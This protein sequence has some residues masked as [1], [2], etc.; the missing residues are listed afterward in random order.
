MEEKKFPS[1]HGK[2]V[3]KYSGA[4]KIQTMKKISSQNHIENFVVIIL[5][6]FP[7]NKT[8]TL[9][10]DFRPLLV[11]WSKSSLFDSS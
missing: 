6:R 4:G 9:N 7:I 1:D 8:K 5:G 10:D 3:T 11:F 2:M